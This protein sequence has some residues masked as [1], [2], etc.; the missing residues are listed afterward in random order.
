MTWSGFFVVLFLLTTNVQ[1][2]LWLHRRGRASMYFASITQVGVKMTIHL[3]R[4]F[5]INPIS[6]YFFR[7][8]L[9]QR[10]HVFDCASTWPDYNN[11]S[12]QSLHTFSST[13]IA[14]SCD[15]RLFFLFCAFRFLSILLH[16]KCV[17]H[18]YYV[19]ILIA[20]FLMLFQFCKSSLSW[21]SWRVFNYNDLTTNDCYGIEYSINDII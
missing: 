3:S 21:R 15:S 14:T 19:V 9:R 20:I 7:A 12:I 11:L 8:W 17:F 4:R 1:I 6:C 5:N 10:T 2:L 13:L 16:E 18:Q